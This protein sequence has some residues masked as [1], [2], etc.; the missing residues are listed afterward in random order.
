MFP[1]ELEDIFSKFDEDDFDLY[2]TRADFSGDN[3][4]TD[5]TLNVQDIN[6]R[7]GISQNWTIKVAGHRKNHVSF[8]FAD[9]MQITDDHPLLWEFTDTQCQLY[10]TGQCKD[11]AKLFFDL[12]ATHKRLFG[13]HQCFNISFGEETP[14]FKPFQYS[15]G[16]LTQGSKKLMEKY[17]D[18]LKQNGLD[19]TIVGERPA[20]YW[21]GEQYILE[22]QD[23][24][25]LFLGDTY[26]IA[27][28]FSFVQQDENSR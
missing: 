3:F 15:N 1:K 26:I 21:D 4:I 27:K 11:T 5:F 14:Y 13:K 10:F 19:F 2:I 22:S 25:V 17:A 23:L 7:G 6:E 9:F 8:D 24:K 12:Y 28:G 16:L 18:C 20:K